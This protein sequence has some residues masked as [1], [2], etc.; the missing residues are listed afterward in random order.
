[1]G[2]T[3]QTDSF[4]RSRNTNFWI[5]PVEVFGSGPN[6]TV[7]GALKLARRW[8]QKANPIDAESAFQQGFDDGAL[9]H[10]D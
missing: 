4:A 6:M 7:R 3:S 1:L 10:F 5:F 8:R 9:R 2:R